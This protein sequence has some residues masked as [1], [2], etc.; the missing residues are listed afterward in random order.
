[1]EDFTLFDDCQRSPSRSKVDWGVERSFTWE[2]E[3]RERLSNCNLRLGELKIR[4][5]VHEELFMSIEPT[6]IGLQ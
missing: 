3:V 2:L 1:M 5:S 4:G 6:G